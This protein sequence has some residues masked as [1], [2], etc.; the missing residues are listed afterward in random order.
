MDIQDIHSHKREAYNVSLTVTDD[1]GCISLPAINTINVWAGIVVAL[2][3]DT[4]CYSPSGVIETPFTGN[5]SGGIN[6]WYW[7]FGGNNQIISNNPNISFAFSS[8][9]P[10]IV[11]LQTELQLPGNVICFCP[12]H[13]DYLCLGFT[14]SCVYC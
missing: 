13:R 9:G 8:P 6:T 3:W 12:I 11:S 5:T 14:R 4:V 10:H 2:T 7:D 1:Q